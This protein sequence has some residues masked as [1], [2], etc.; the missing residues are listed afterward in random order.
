MKICQI[1]TSKKSFPARM[2][3]KRKFPQ[4]LKTFKSKPVKTS[5]N[6]VRVNNFDVMIAPGTDFS[7][8][9]ISA[10]L[11]RIVYYFYLLFA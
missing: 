7:L 5:Y 11:T 3:N 1:P 6:E 9:K 10:G 8:G 4:K 2:N